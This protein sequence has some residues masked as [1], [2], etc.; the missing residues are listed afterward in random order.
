MATS[1]EWRANDTSDPILGP[2]DG[3]LFSCH[4][5]SGSDSYPSL[6]LVPPVTAK[7]THSGIADSSNLPPIMS[8]GPGDDLSPPNAVDAA[9]MNGIAV[10]V[11][12]SAGWSSS[13]PKQEGVYPS[14]VAYDLRLRTNQ[15]RNNN[16][17]SSN[18][19]KV[20]AESLELIA[21]LEY[22]NPN[23]EHGE[24]MM[25]KVAVAKT[26]VQAEIPDAELALVAA[27]FQEFIPAKNQWLDITT[28]V[29]YTQ[30]ANAVVAAVLEDT[31]RSGQTAGKA[32]V[33]AEK[34]EFTLGP[35]SA[36]ARIN[37]TFQTDRLFTYDA[38]SLKADASDIGSQRILPLWV[39]LPFAPVNHEA[40]LSQ[41]DVRFRAPPG[42]SIMPIDQYKEAYQHLKSQDSMKTTTILAVSELT[43]LGDASGDNGA[44]FKFQWGSL[45]TR[46]CGILAWLALPNPVDDYD[47]CG[48]DFVHIGRSLEE[49]SGSVQQLNDINT[50]SNNKKSRAHAVIQ[51]PSNEDLA[52]LQVPLPGHGPMGSLWRVK[53]K[54]PEAQARHKP[55]WILNL[56]ISDKSGSTMTQVDSVGTTMRQR[57]N[58]LAEAR[59]LKRLESIPALLQAGVLRSEDVWMDVFLPFDSAA[60]PAWIH[61]VM[62]RIADVK[63][64]IAEVVAAIRSD[65]LDLARSKLPSVVRYVLALRGVSPGGL[66]NFSAGA[67]TLIKEFGQWQRE[68]QSLVQETITPCS[69]VEFDTDGGH[70]NSGGYLDSLQRLCEIYDVRNGLV[71]G[72]GSWLNQDCASKVARVLGSAPAQ[73]AL[74]VPAAGTEGMDKIFRRGFSAWVSALRQPPKIDV[75]ISA[76]SVSFPSS[77]STYRN[78]N[79]VDVV[80]FRRI[81]DR[82][83]KMPKF[84]G[85]DIANEEFTKAAIDGVSAGEELIVYIVS[86]L[87][88][89]AR[90]METLEIETSAADS[91]VRNKATTTIE[92][93]NSIGNFLAFDWLTM[94]TTQSGKKGFQLSPLLATSLRSR[95]ED[96]V[97]F[98][99]NIA[100]PS[101]STSFLGRC[102]TVA[103]RPPI[104][105]AHQP[106]PPDSPLKILP[107]TPTHNDTQRKAPIFR[108]HAGGGYVCVSSKKKKLN[109][110]GAYGS[111]PAVSCGVSLDSNNNP[112]FQ[113]MDYRAPEVTRSVGSPAMFGSGARM[114][115]S[116]SQ[117]PSLM[118]YRQRDRSMM[119][120]SSPAPAS[121]SPFSSQNTSQKGAG[122]MASRRVNRYSSPR[123]EQHQQTQQKGRDPSWMDAVAVP[124]GS[125]LPISKQGYNEL[126]TALR[127]I[128][129]A[130]QRLFG[131]SGITFVCDNCNRQ[132]EPG[133]SRYHCF[134]CQ[135]FDV[136]V[137]CRGCH[138]IPFHRV[139]MK[140]PVAVVS[141]DVPV[142]GNDPLIDSLL[143]ATTDTVMATSMAT[144]VPS[145]P[146]IDQTVVWST[147]R[148]RRFLAAALHWWP[149]FRTS[150]DFCDKLPDSVDGD[151][152]QRISRCTDSGVDMAELLNTAKIVLDSLERLDDSLLTIPVGE[153]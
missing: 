13:P 17:S 14:A 70:N 60:L 107:P 25:V 134:D 135:D 10:P 128:V 139:E 49:L 142:T 61:K 29:D 131:D 110:K 145:P 9:K 46:S 136:C 31:T 38:M 85:P 53:V 34:I 43:Q 102:K 44:G 84:G 121:A 18:S 22:T 51:V 62:F 3:R 32:T 50:D 79:A 66:T 21:T 48:F 116:L 113:S 77:R 80:S 82:H 119:P 109:A 86:R 105:S 126:K 99:F 96:E 98:R 87:D 97:C 124:I 92:D 37:L 95:L 127:E 151:L 47:D 65:N 111:Q 76:G 132:F 117:Q 40:G 55:Y 72:F 74:S 101:G 148:I 153:Y 24:S 141:R 150:C 100:S 140:S 42:T 138:T 146:K 88:S 118:H 58:Q 11:A 89:A 63:D 75:K 83:E 2:D 69:F 41:L 68:A 120:Q 147:N 7:D 103:G 56:T 30:T 27:Q 133:E 12:T 130:R 57:F 26:L 54:M 71:T 16:K 125:S 4:H 28:D 93:E 106:S 67:N 33:T 45:P 90:L 91:C 108:P 122:A 35:F 123:A 114:L 137:S 5:P 52:S 36:K 64:L 104:G 6:T 143:G 73:L 8:P 20:T 1:F 78:A 149:L 144:L 129:H 19:S 59:F 15:S 23:Y 39:T 152:S 81:G 115:H 112:V 94:L